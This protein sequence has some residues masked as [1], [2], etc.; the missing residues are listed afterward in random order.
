VASPEEDRSEAR[1]ILKEL[2]ANQYQAIVLGGAALA[3]LISLNPLPLL[4]WLGGELVMLPILD[5][6]PLRRM[7]RRR[8]LARARQESATRR[9]QLIAALNQANQRR[10]AELV[11]LC[12]LIE[13][14]Y[15]GLHGI[16]AAYLS[17]Q[18]EKLDMIL[19]S[20]AHR[21][22]AIQRYELLLVNRNPDRVDADIERLER[23]LADP[24]LNDRARAAIQKNLELKRKLLASLSDARGTIRA[25]ATELDSLASLLEVL[26][27]NSISMRDPQAVSQELDTIVRQSEESERV[28]R[29]MEALLA[30]DA[31]GW[32]GAAVPPL[33]D[34]VIVPP[35]PADSAAAPERTRR[36]AR[37]R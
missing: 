21:M 36:K 25:L 5:S 37:E 29:E 30:A 26:H 15:Q 19:Y 4:V 3:S 12:Q 11:H 31:S 28:V 17:E 27:Q 34:H 10:Y 9:A 14:N 16:S 22:L 24:E 33:P 2:I 18:R 35:L 1:S 20:C 23:E 32:S 8:R 6:G 13:A 7:V